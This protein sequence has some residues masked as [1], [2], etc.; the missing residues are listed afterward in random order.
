[1]ACRVP[2]ASSVQEFWSNLCNGVE[3]IRALTPEDLRAAGMSDEE[4]ADPKHV[5]A[6]ATID[7]IDCFDAGFFGITAREAEIMDPQHRL[8]LECA[9]HALEDAGCDPFR[10]DGAIGVFGGGIF[11]SYATVN[12]LPN[13]VFDDATDV[14]SSVLANEKDYLVTRV[15][16]KLNLRGPSINVQSGCSTSLL[17]IHLACQSLLNYES[18]VALAGGTSIDVRRGQGYHYSEGSVF[19][20]DGHCRA[21]DAKA[22]GTVFG[23]GVGIVALKRVEDAIADGNT[24]YAVVLGSATNNDGSHKVGF[25][26]PSV[27]G[28]SSVISEAL[29][30]AGVEPDTIGYV[31][32]HGTGTAL[33]DPIEIEAM[34]RAFGA[35]VGRQSCPIG[36]V[37]ASVGH[38]DAAAGVS[39]FIKAVLAL[40]RKKVPPSVNFT[41]PNPKIDFA[42]SPFY[43]NTA[44]TDW[45]AGTKPNVPRRA[46]VSSFGMGGTNVHVVLE[47]APSA[48]PAPAAQSFHLLVQSAK[49]LAALDESTTRL[50]SYLAAG[51]DVDLADVAHTLQVGRGVFSFRRVAVCSDAADAAGAL[52]TLDP[53]RVSTRPYAGE[54]FQVA[55]MFPGQGAQRPGTGRELYDREPVFRKHLDAACKAFDKHLGADLRPLLYPDPSAREQAAAQ[56]TRTEF[57][58][59]ALF[60]IE[61]ALAQL[62]ISW[63]VKPGALIGH[64]VGEYVAACLAGV[65]SFDDAVR[66]VAARARLMQQ[67]PAGAMTAVFLPAAEIE[68]LG[69]DLAIAAING[70][71]FSVV[72]G[73][74]DAIDRFERAAADRGITCTRLQTSHAFHSS[75]M[76]GVVAPFVEEV[77]KARLSA[78]KV[79]FVSNVTGTWIK[80]TE[81]VDPQYWGRHLRAPVRFADGIKALISREGLHLLE[82]G[83]GRTLCSF[84][85]SMNADDRFTGA[86]LPHASDPTPERSLILQSIGELWLRGA[87]IDWTALGAGDAR[88]RIPLPHYPFERTR[89]WLEAEK[90][91][92]PPVASG[93]VLEKFADVGRWL[94]YPEWRQTPPVGFSSHHER[95]G[96]DANWLVFV[97][98][99]TFGERVL[100]QL[101][102]ASDP[103]RIV[104][105]EPGPGFEAIG[106]RRYTIDPLRRDDYRR[107]CAELDAAGRMPQ[108]VAHLWASSTTADVEDADA[109]ERAQYRGF[110]SVIWLAQALIAHRCDDAEPVSFKVVTAGV[111]QIQGDER[112]RPERATLLGPCRVIHQEHSEIRC[113]AIDVPLDADT[114]VASLVAQ[115]LVVLT[116]DRFVACRGDRRWTPL[117]EPV[118]I[119]REPADP[120][121]LRDG[122]TYLITGGLG[123]IGTTLARHL[124][125]TRRARLVL[126]TRGAFPDRASWSAWLESHGDADPTSQRI[127]TVREIEA[128]GGDVVVATADVADEDGMRRVL[129]AAKDR[130]GGIHGVI[131]AAGLAGAGS[132]ERGAERTASVL[133]PVEAID[134]P[135][136]QSQFRPKMRGLFVLERVLA[137]E[138]VDFCLVVSSLSAVLGGLGYATYAAANCF[139]DAFVRR[140]NQRPGVRWLTANWDAWSF[141]APDSSAS[142][143]LSQMTLTPEEGVDVFERV[144]R[145]IG[146]GQIVIS[147]GSLFHRGF[148]TKTPAK[149]EK[150]AAGTHE[151]KR[152]KAERELYARPA[153]LEASFEAPRSDLER[154]I[155][156]IWQQVIGIDRV[157]RRDNFFA[158]GGHSLLAVQVA[159][160]LE[161]ALSMQIPMRSLFDSATVAE[162]AARIETVLG[163]DWQVPALAGGDRGDEIE[164]LEL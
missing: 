158:L 149:V 62:W 98:P 112:V 48:S 151:V 51:N 68:D 138:P 7:H 76:D 73:P 65:F 27:T 60:A 77:K 142:S 97:E 30:D 147:V 161:A 45:T 96:A 18:D 26:A 78:P 162:L 114:R 157:G 13:G 136:C 40:N 8:F 70:P 56:L 79:P 3:S 154:T 71:R 72:A 41:T 24:I 57:A 109:T 90:A 2:G 148:Q 84:A 16:Y 74:I 81:A 145:G 101:S 32:T 141:A 100:E 38:L 37:K 17:A 105:V 25:T 36:S 122:G 99:A 33:G 46:G 52:S 120:S 140:H 59:P 102:L 127:R 108:A 129:A 88:R 23:N 1:M 49:T 61:Y 89:Y 53:K 106:D 54:R 111:Q 15:S 29:A 91:E 131:H 21:F 144:M 80:P 117:Y 156:G 103:L 125:A 121:P 124:A 160:R 4:I 43:V 22:Q 146:L 20:R 75:M 159:A 155:A 69:P 132:M 19:S 118:A 153:S 93:P 11:D 67:V 130:F 83:P 95:I 107:L 85:K 143:V 119:N 94:Y 133:E 92:E 55:F 137:D 123:A 66:I 58:Q 128:L 139:M 134:V 39:G 28:Q 42:S 9:W 64:S 63:G 47:E 12:L 115:E 31:E 34:T 87:E 86:S 82:V 110:F 104:T 116:P 5:A 10:Y 152:P 163:D 50:A 135:G 113:C 14:L 126:V 35:R 44:L 6:A 150:Q 164:E